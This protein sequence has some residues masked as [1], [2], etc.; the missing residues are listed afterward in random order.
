MQD[1]SLVFVTLVQV[2]QNSNRIPVVTFVNTSLTVIWSCLLCLMQ[3][4]RCPV[5][6][7]FNILLLFYRLIKWMCN[8]ENM[9]FQIFEQQKSCLGITLKTIQSLIL[10][11]FSVFIWH[12]Y[13]AG[14]E[15]E[16]VDS[17]SIVM[18][19]PTLRVT[20]MH[21]NSAILAAKSPFFFKVIL[22]TFWNASF[23]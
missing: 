4:N 14:D 2:E 17:S 22:M 3:L 13:F 11:T 23:L 1:F 12:W 7:M 19:A 10:H 16:C 5:F 9:L 18:A 8:I 15:G 20:T 21:I 6:C